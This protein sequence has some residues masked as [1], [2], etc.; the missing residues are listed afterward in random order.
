MLPLYLNISFLVLLF[1]QTITCRCLLCPEASTCSLLA[2]V[3]SNAVFRLWKPKITIHW[4]NGEVAEEKNKWTIKNQSKISTKSSIF[5]PW[6]IKLPVTKSK[7]YGTFIEIHH[8]MTLKNGEDF[9]C[10]SKGRLD[11]GQTREKMHPKTNWK[12]LFWLQLVFA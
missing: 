11:W 12:F 3:Y 1:Y 6:V 4:P 8:S 10:R 2:Y 7:I 5:R 9:S